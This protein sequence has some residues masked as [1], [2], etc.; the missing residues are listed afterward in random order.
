MT[1][2]LLVTNTQRPCTLASLEL[3]SEGESAIRKI[4]VNYY[5]KNFIGIIE[6]DLLGKIDIKQGL[7]QAF[8]L[9]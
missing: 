8:L 6:I 1:G 5:P 7:Y 3:S 4:L 2:G 9:V